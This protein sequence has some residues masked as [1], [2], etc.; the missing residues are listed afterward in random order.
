MSD[1]FLS[2]G[3]ED[4]ARAEQIAAAL[5]AQGWSV[6]WDRTIPAGKT[7]HEIIDQALVEARCVV[8]LWSK[9]SVKK[10]WVLEEAQEGVDRGILIPVLIDKV[11]LPRGFRRV[12]SATLVGWDGDETASALRKLVSDIVGLLGAPTAE[13]GAVS[14]QASELATESIEAVRTDQAASFDEVQEAA[15]SDHQRSEFSIPVK[16][17]DQNR[18]QGIDPQAKPDR[19]S[20]AIAEASDDKGISSK[21]RRPAQ[22][23]PKSDSQPVKVEHEVTTKGVKKG[24]VLSAIVAVVIV[25]IIG[26]AN[27]QPVA[28][29][30]VP[31]SVTE[32]RTDPEKKIPE[33][34]AGFGWATPAVDID[35]ETV[36]LF[37]NEA[38]Q[39]DMETQ[40]QL[41]RMYEFGWG[42][43]RNEAAAQKWYRK[44]AEQ[45]HAGAKGALECLESGPAKCAMNSIRNIRA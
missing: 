24:I 25:V 38:E 37:R 42:V 9:T 11:K 21:P 39:G 34:S 26:V 16:I 14:A 1:I 40:Y 8:V 43:E 35:A 30:E 33:S 17:A 13:V 20:V 7:F 41:G 4:A 3:S 12:Q 18:S 19:P 6:W 10:N 5:A 44:A 2:Y 31:A 36:E 29:K 15:P 23:Q 32:P 28:T 45:G 27:Q 22:N